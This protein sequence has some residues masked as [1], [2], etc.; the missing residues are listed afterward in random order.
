[1]LNRRGVVITP[2]T[3]EA[4]GAVLFEDAL[5]YSFLE[6]AVSITANTRGAA[7]RLFSRHCCLMLLP[8]CGAKGKIDSPWKMF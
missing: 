5:S 2:D 7:G 6:T 8:R 1:M 4:F 3:A